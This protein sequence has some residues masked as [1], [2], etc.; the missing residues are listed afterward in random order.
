[1]TRSAPDIDTHSASAIDAAGL[2][3]S[4][5]IRTGFALPSR[6]VPPRAVLGW[7][8]AAL[9]LAAGGALAAVTFAAGPT[10]TVEEAAGPAATSTPPCVWLTQVDGPVVPAEILGVA[11]FPGSLL[12]FEQC[13][14]RWTGDMAWMT[15][16][17]EEMTSTTPGEAPATQG[18]DG[19][20]NPWEA[21]NQ[22]V[23]QWLDDPAGPVPNR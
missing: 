6:L 4:E 7:A 19:L 15:A 3:N 10:G 9:V 2:R 8:V 22:A 16:W 18:D 5:R 20:P 1:M 13:D 11:P 17:T 12:V 21:G 14:G 23:E